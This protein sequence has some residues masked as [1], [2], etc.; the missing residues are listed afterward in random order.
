MHLTNAE[1]GSLKLIILNGPSGVGKSTTAAA[2]HKGMPLSL[3]I[4]IDELRRWISGY[5]EH[6][7]ESLSLANEQALSAA[8][9]H[10]RLGHTVIIDKS[11]IEAEIVDRMHALGRQYGADIHEII[12][13]ARKDIVQE[14]A[15][16]R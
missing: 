7:K 11:I 16:A 9:T 1:I 12:L 14:R 4:E 2:L 3:R 13:I 8:E 15:D 6:T 5:R 10:L